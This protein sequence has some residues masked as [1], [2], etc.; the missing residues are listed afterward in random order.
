MSKHPSHNTKRDLLRRGLA[1]I[2]TLALLLGL[3][4]AAA[5]PAH[6]ASWA[7]PYIQ[8]LVD[9]G[10]MRGDVNGNMAPGRN[11]TR[12]EFVTLINRAYGYT[13]LG[14]HPFT[15]VSSRDWYNEDI[16]IAYNIGYFKGTGPTT[17]SPNSALTREQ[18]AVLLSRNMMLQPT[19]GETLG[20]TDS[21]TLSDWSR[22]LVGA[23]AAN[24]VLGGYEDGS[25]RP[26]RSITRGEVA[27]MLVRA[28]GTPVQSPGDH[29]LGNVYGNVTV[30]TSGVTLRD[31]VIAGNLYLTG[32]IDLG[33]VLLENVTVL[34]RIVISGGG[35][36]NSSQSSVIL[37][38]VAADGMVVDSIG[39]QFVTIR[40]EGN[41]DI[42]DTVVRTNAYVDDSSLPG[43]GLSHITLDGE[44]GALYQLAGNV[45]EVL[46]K[47][48]GSSLQVV[49]GSAD[50]V[51]VDEYAAGSSVFVDGDAVVDDLNL[52]TATAVTGTGD[53]KGL[54]VGAAGSTVE[55]LPDKIVIRPGITADVAGSNMNSS[56]A[57]ESSADPKLM[58]GYPAVR[59][60]APNSAQLVFRTNK[61]GTVYWAVSAV[62]DGS[63]S[64][65]DLLDPPAYGGKVLASGSVSAASANTDY[66][67]AVSKLT[68]GGSYYV[69]AMLV[70]GRDQHS[71]I[72][73][74]SFTTPDNTTP[75]FVK[76]YP[77]ITKNT[78]ANA[79][80][81]VMT[82]KSCLLYYALLPDGAAAP[83]AEEFKAAAIPGNLGY[84][85]MSVTKNVT[86][87]FQINA[88]RLNEKTDY[89]LYLWLVD[90]DG[91]KQSRVTSL[92]FTTPDETPPKATASQTKCTTDTITL[93]YT[94]N[95]PADLV[96]ALV[97]EGDHDAKRFMGAW[98]E[99]PE[100]AD[101]FTLRFEDEAQ[102]LAAKVWLMSGQGALKSS[103]STKTSPFTIT[104]LKPEETGT[105]YVLYYI[106][107]DKATASGNL[108]EEIKAVRVH[109][110]DKVRPTAE[111]RF[112]NPDGTEVTAD[113]QANA[114]IRIIFSENVKGGTA[115]G[116]NVFLTLYGDVQECRKA[117]KTAQDNGDTEAEQAAQTNLD[118]ALK[119]YTKVLSTYIKLYKGVPD[120]THEEVE[121]RTGDTDPDGN[122][123]DWRNAQVLKLDDGSGRLEIRLPTEDETGTEKT[124]AIKLESGSS[125]YFHLAG[126]YDLAVV[127]NALDPSPCDLKFTTSFAKVQLD[128]TSYRPA[129]MAKAVDKDGA[130]L[131]ENASTVEEPAASTVASTATA[132][133]PNASRNDPARI[134]LVLRVQPL[135][136][137]DNVDKSIYYDLLLWS[138]TNAEITLYSR[139]YGSKDAWV[140]EGSTTFRGV[141]DEAGGYVYRGLF[142]DILGKKPYG[143]LYQM[144]DKEYAIHV[145]RLNQMT[146]LSPDYA[147]WSGT[148]NM[149]ASVVAGWSDPELNQLHESGRDYQKTYDELVPDTLRSIGT[150]DPRTMKV[151][152]ADT[153]PP[154]IT[155]I[156]IVESDTSPEISIIMDHP[157]RVNYVVFPLTDLQYLD[158]T[159]RK[160]IPAGTQITEAM[161][162]GTDTKYK[163]DSYSAAARIQLYDTATQKPAA[164]DAKVGEITP[165]RGGSVT[166]TPLE[167]PTADQVV[168][169]FTDNTGT[170][171]GVIKGKTNFVSS[172]ITARIPLSDLEPNTIYVLLAV[173]QGTT[174][175]SYAKRAVAYRFTTQ[176]PSRPVIKLSGI[177][178]DVTAEVD[179]TSVVRARLL[180]LGNLEAQG[181]DLILNKKLADNLDLNA[182]ALPTEYADLTILDALCT[183]TATGLKPSVFDVYASETAKNAVNT[184]VSTGGGL[185]QTSVGEWGGQQ[186]HKVTVSG[187]EP[188]NTADISFSRDN[189]FA[190]T[191]Y[192]C[193]AMA[194]SSRSGAFAYCAIKPLQVL[195]NEPPKVTASAD[196]YLDDNGKITGTIRV[197]FSKPLYR[198]DIEGKELLPVEHNAGYALDKTKTVAGLGGCFGSLTGG[199]LTIQ[200][201]TSLSAPIGNVTFSVTPTLSK[202]FTISISPGILRN[203]WDTLVP[204]Q[205]I[206]IKVKVGADGS[207]DSTVSYV[208]L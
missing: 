168:D 39:S 72:K 40:A 91:A 164:G 77:R 67:A 115:K 19:V 192:V 155:S 116:E 79:Q 58:A 88:V 3:L 94:V 35:E 120:G 24:G 96:W 73:V 41:T 147:S 174:A 160:A 181:D 189:L 74:T 54:N 183:A 2:L 100:N 57:A 42:P 184:L 110:E 166:G 45:Q 15:D 165:I 17:A 51:T 121:E 34:G 159:T 186:G 187:S 176:M 89:V 63:V 14:G 144:E 64:E 13:K 18:A 92:K 135:F 195:D 206:K 123:I 31:G 43:Y 23:A 108:S 117:V 1:G 152:F 99:D 175:A 90:H 16:D 207:V 177:S 139:A 97:T 53:I 172:N 68:T 28:I 126:I 46:N 163:I 128:V 202:N 65:A 161:I 185:G 122:W 179:R 198:K 103:S 44:D 84:G 26:R 87:P 111:L 173:P 7:D 47:T 76:T 48:P 9:W 203:Q 22:G 197:N 204:A 208:K 56:Q 6:A 112:T 4:P 12:A 145:D 133:Y 107:N 61:P 143:T 11:I 101:S 200:T 114:D 106:A 196:L 102:L 169:G 162:R 119:A 148:V 93:A 29:A 130:T 180:V 25:F 158:G 131:F 154:N 32:G 127:P 83:T 134:D 55:Q 95:E 178:T 205:D 142:Y 153:Q 156:S 82:N 66:T 69:T 78:C 37:R 137:P 170:T 109:T 104:G 38:N 5:A 138:D 150:P 124:S 60:I 113:P 20:F 146:V 157:G 50:K 86:T 59:K 125:Y 52:D 49:Q 21:R 149:K 136:S 27:A 141:S 194:Q 30:N 81:T 105:N 167:L 129:V 8:T 33:E 85:S 151:T 132:L 140:R 10:V 80:A 118:N 75:A 182:G 191:D 71:P 193:I 188:S 199:P 70:D 171:A 62:A 98:T 190:N 36:S 201:D